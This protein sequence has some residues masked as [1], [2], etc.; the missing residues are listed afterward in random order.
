MTVLANSRFPVFT[1][2]GWRIAI[3]THQGRIE[4][5]SRDAQYFPSFAAALASM[6]HPS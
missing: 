3:V 6:E 4:A 1:A 5:A 2:R